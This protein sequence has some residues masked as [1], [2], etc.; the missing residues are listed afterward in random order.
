[1]KRFY[2]SL[3]LFICTFSCFA[4]ISTWDIGYYVDEFGDKTDEAFLHS[5]TIN[6]K[7]GNSKWE[8]QDCRIL[9]DDKYVSF[10]VGDTYY[11]D[12]IIRTKTPEGEIH[13]YKF[14]FDGSSRRLYS[15]YQSEVVGILND[16]L[17]NSRVIAVPD[18]KYSTDKYDFGIVSIDLE[19]LISIRPDF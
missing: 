1:M 7:Y 3:M 18:N 11:N 12:W 10:Y 19:T 5:E 9:I 16:I 6:I 13:S 15:Y 4:N 8:T 2:L 14:I 17:K